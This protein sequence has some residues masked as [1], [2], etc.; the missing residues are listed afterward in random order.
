MPLPR[1]L[2]GVLSTWCLP[3]FSLSLAPALKGVARCCGRS[4]SRP[5]RAAPETDE[6]TRHPASLPLP[7]PLLLTLKGP[8]HLV[9]ALV[10][11]LVTP[12]TEGCAE[13][14]VFLSFPLS[15]RDGT[16]QRARCPGP[17]PFL[18]VLLVS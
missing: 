10:L 3:S 17:A 8:R 13:G 12:G 14:L 15:L 6:R 5:A 4:R 2:E 9:F 11:A 7:L 18:L 16:G 1:T